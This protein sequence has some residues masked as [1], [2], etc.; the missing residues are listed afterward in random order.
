MGVSLGTRDLSHTSSSRG[1]GTLVRNLKTRPPSPK[2][3][4]GGSS[5]GCHRR[6]GR[7]CGCLQVWELNTPLTPLSSPV[8]PL[9]PALIRAP[10]EGQRQPQNPESLGQHRH[11]AGSS[12]LSHQA[13]VA[14]AAPSSNAFLGSVFKRK[15]GRELILFVCVCGGPHPTPACL[16]LTSVSHTDFRGPGERTQPTSVGSGPGFLRGRSPPLHPTARPLTLPPP[17]LGPAPPVP[18]KAGLVWW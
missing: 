5:G 17:C 8:L 1:P 12:T 14:S 15:R 13:C 10:G 9:S 3:R 11:G 16:S 2:A 7:D 6:L 18:R 4:V